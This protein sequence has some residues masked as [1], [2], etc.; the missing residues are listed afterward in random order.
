MHA[1]NQDRSPRKILGQFFPAGF[2]SVLRDFMPYFH[3]RCVARTT[4]DTNLIHSAGACFLVM[5]CVGYPRVQLKT[6][7]SLLNYVFTAS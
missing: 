7:L 5:A 2:I 3:F 1:K 4:F 6:L